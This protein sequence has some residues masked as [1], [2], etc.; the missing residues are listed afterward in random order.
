MIDFHVY[1]RSHESAKC[2]SWIMNLLDGLI[3]FY[4]AGLDMSVCIILSDIMSFCSFCSSSLFMKKGCFSWF[5]TGDCLSWFRQHP[6]GANKT[7][8]VVKCCV[9]YM[10]G[11]WLIGEKKVHSF[12]EENDRFVILMNKGPDCEVLIGTG[13]APLKKPNRQSRQLEKHI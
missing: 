4:Y 5:P 9:C 3:W 2:C 10:N 6:Q 1:K 13:F 11:I 7:N 8:K 12:K